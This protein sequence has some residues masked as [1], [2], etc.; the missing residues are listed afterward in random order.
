[1]KRFLAIIPVALFTTAGLFAFMAY[2]IDSDEVAPPNVIDTP[3][4]NI[5]QT[6]EDSPKNEIDRRIPQPPEPTPPMPTQTM[7]PD[8]ASAPSDFGYQPSGLEIQTTKANLSTLGGAPDNDARPI[9]QVNPKYPIDAARNGTEGWVKL[10]FDINAIG[11]VI[12]VRVLDSLPKRIF[13]GAAKKALRRWKY[14]AK[15]IDGKPVVQQNITVQLDFK[16]DQQA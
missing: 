4:V 5:Y 11:E 2:L 10:A 1:M 13:D 16:M 6:P 9:V 3:L 12:N 14:Q 15:T 7:T 8:T